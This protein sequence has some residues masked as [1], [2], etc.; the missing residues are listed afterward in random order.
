[1]ADARPAFHY[2]REGNKTGCWQCGRCGFAYLTEH[3]ANACGC[4]YGERKKGAKRTQ[5]SG[6]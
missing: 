3:G 6:R 2:D 4:K 1:M 5:T